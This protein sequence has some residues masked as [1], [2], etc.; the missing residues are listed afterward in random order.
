MRKF[1]KQKAASVDAEMYELKINDLNI[2][3]NHQ[4]SSYTAPVQIPER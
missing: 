1:E 2:I 4:C 3:K